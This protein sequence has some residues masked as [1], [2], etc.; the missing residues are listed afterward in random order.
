MK[1]RYFAFMLAAAAAVV[2][3]N[4]ENIEDTNTPSKETEVKYVDVRLTAA[5]EGEEPHSVTGTKTGISIADGKGHVSWSE[6]DKISV[7]DNLTEETDNKHNN[8]FSISDDLKGFNGTLP[9]PGVTT[10]AYALY[11]YRTGATFNGSTIATTLLAEQE[12][13]P[14][15]FANGTAIMAGKVNGTEIAFKNLCSHIKFNLTEENVKSIT[16]MGNKSEALCGTFNITFNEAGEP[17]TEITKPE[18]YITL[19]N[20]TGSTA[21]EANKD[22]YF[23]TLPVDFS[24][25]FTIILSYMDGTQKVKSVNKQVQLPRSKV[26]PLSTPSTFDE[27][28]INYFVKY[29]DGF[30][31]TIGDYAFNKKD[32]GEAVLIN[33]TKK[34]GDFYQ[35][36]VYFI[37]SDESST[38]NINKAA[39]YQSLIIVGADSEK[40][41]NLRFTKQIKAAEG[42]EI[43]ALSNLTC[44][45]IDDKNAFGQ[46]SGQKNLGEIII[47]NCHFLN[48]GKQFFQFTQDNVT[49]LKIRIE[50]CEFGMNVDETQKNVRPYIVNSGGKSN[51]FNSFIFNNN[52]VYNYNSKQHSDFR[53]IA[54]DNTS[55]NDFYAELNTFDNMPITTGNFC[56]I[57][58]LTNSL[59]FRNNFFIECN[60]NTGITN[61][62]T[63]KSADIDKSIIT[64]IITYNFCFATSG[65]MNSGLATDDYPN[66]TIHS[67]ATLDANPLSESW[68]PQNDS[69]GSYKSVTYNSGKKMPANTPIGAQRPDMTE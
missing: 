16:I 23:T 53:L 55:V 20:G 56:R 14:E 26:A 38:A 58:K 33:Q 57:G 27:G 68:N 42:C 6:G 9:E 41:A 32:K 66:L 51:N 13:V 39:S 5:L 63:F 40:R 69:Y 37:D 28:R 11:P 3:C 49:S 21:I 29:N 36:G 60:S 54:G 8:V 10:A 15:T 65:K 22:Y 18:T 43:I 34:N 1:K 45:G 2:A 25:G 48:V 30:D 17:T 31:I 44:D 59:T 47:S 61:I 62:F 35:D 4:K 24:E 50:D 67:I 7:F 12:A 19:R 52:I 64:G 46:S